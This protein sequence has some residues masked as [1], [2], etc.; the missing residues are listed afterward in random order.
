MNLNLGVQENALSK[1]FAVAP[2]T[3]H[4]E[5]VTSQLLALWAP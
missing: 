1:F 4:V 2:N 3:S 5:L